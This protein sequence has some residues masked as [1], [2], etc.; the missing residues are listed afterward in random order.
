MILNN[1]F[2]IFYNNYVYKIYH[3]ILWILLVNL[4]YFIK[5]ETYYNIFKIFHCLKATNVHKI[6]N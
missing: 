4:I 1:G 5:T 6:S 3:D 2:Y